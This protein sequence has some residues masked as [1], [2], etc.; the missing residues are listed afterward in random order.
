MKLIAFSLAFYLLLGS[1]LPGAD[2]GQ[3]GK[4]P[5]VM[6]HYRLHQQMAAETGST[7]SFHQFLIE[8]FWQTDSHDHGDGGKSHQDLPLKHLQTM[9]H[10][11]LQSFRPLIQPQ[12]VIKPLLFPEATEAYSST[13]LQGVFRPPIG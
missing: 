7:L 9:D 2:Y 8:H 3:L 5:R 11:V 1:F 13:A 12:L 10:M 6:E 4:L